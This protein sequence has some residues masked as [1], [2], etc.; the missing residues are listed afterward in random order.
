M[1]DHS[2]EPNPRPGHD[3]PDTTGRLFEPPEGFVYSAVRRNWAIV[4]IVAIL[5][6]AAGVA[7]GTLRKNPSDT[8][9][10][11]TT[12]QV[13]QVNP[14]SPGFYGY[15]QSSAALATAFSRAIEAEPVLEAVH[16]SL[17][18]TIPEASA[19]LSAA[20]IPLSP[21]FRVI[22]TGPT[23][24]AA[25]RLANTAAGALTAYVGESNSA[26]P[27]AK[28]LLHEYRGAALALTNATAQAARLRV[29]KN[30]PA[31]VLAAARAEVDAG[32]LKLRATGDAYTAAISSQAPRSGLV[33]L[34]ASATS[35]SGSKTSKI[36]LY[37]I[38]GLLI[39]VV[40][41]SGLAML[42]ER[43]RPHPSAASR[44]AYSSQE[45]A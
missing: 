41:G 19:R 4:L 44:H 27:E 45:H 42:Q 36:E 38:I 11:S 8:Y 16:H 22:A 33:T 9:T 5:L 40:T 15:V 13:G 18:L 43:R 23:A 25:I 31:S 34:L 32:E 14:N 39:G 3:S 21:A 30:T 12:L 6:A 20:P 7:I 35:A 24:S 10:A 17:G 37:G 28:S 29:R 26:N 1:V 2:Q